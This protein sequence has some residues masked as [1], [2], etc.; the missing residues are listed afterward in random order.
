M[1]TAAAYPEKVKINDGIE[2]I[3]DQIV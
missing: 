1:G 2:F 3:V